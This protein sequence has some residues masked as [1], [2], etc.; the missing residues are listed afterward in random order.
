MGHVVVG[1]GEVDGPLFSL[2]CEQAESQKNLC[3]ILRVPTN[4]L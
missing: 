2:Q 1:V 4:A 3:M